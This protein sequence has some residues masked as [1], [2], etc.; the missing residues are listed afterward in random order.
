MG[1]GAVTPRGSLGGA[2]TSGAVSSCLSEPESDIGCWIELASPASDAE[3]AR[4]GVDGLDIENADV[5]R[6]MAELTRERSDFIPDMVRKSCCGITK[7]SAAAGC[8][9]RKGVEKRGVGRRGSDV[10]HVLSAARRGA[11]QVLLR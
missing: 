11:Q 6:R 9:R 1:L 7:C 8:S 3:S 5:E 4:K 2:S 10:R